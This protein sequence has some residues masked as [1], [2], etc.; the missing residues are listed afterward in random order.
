M[1]GPFNIEIYDHDD[2]KSRSRILIV[3]DDPDIT[4]T[5]NLGLAKKGFAVTVFNDPLKALSEFRAGVYDLI[6]LDVKMPKMNGFELSREIEKIDD[7]PKVCYITSFVVYYE[8]LKEIFPAA[9]VCCF[10]K[11][12]I[13]I[14]RLANKITMELNGSNDPFS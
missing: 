13:E 8:S 4:V 11:K 14:D 5:F 1:H 2:N 12:P 9:K 6:L 7:I 10:I 3:D